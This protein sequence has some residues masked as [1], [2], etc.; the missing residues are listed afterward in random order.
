MITT[1]YKGDK[2]AW[3]LNGARNRKQP[4]PE[5]PQLPPVYGTK[6]LSVPKFIHKLYKQT[7]KELNSDH[8]WLIDSDS[9]RSWFTAPTL[10]YLFNHG[11]FNPPAE[12]MRQINSMYGSIGERI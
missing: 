6:G 1:V 12:L 11:S 8:I 9:L 4:A 10:N 7:E 2:T 3:R 5:K